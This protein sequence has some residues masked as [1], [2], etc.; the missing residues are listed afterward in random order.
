LSTTREIS[1]INAKLIKGLFDLWFAASMPFFTTFIYVSAYLAAFLRAPIGMHTLPMLAPHFGN[2]SQFLHLVLILL[3]AN[4]AIITQTHTLYYVPMPTPTI[5][6]PFSVE[7]H[8]TADYVP[9]ATLDGGSVTRYQKVIVQS[10]A[11]IHNPS[12]INSLDPTATTIISQPIT[13][14]CMWHTNSVRNF[15]SVLTSTCAT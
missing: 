15:V 1:D 4:A 12:P 8:E 13:G 10:L 9:I 2:M 6:S 11:V 3:T 5:S 7:T 14:T